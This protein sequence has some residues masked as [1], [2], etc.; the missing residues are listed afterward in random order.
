M[1][2]LGVDF[3]S[4]SHKTAGI[5]LREENGKHIVYDELMISEELIADKVNHIKERQP[6]FNP[7]HWAYR[8]FGDSAA[9]Q[10]RMEFGKLGLPLTSWKK[11]PVVAAIDCVRTLFLQDKLFIMDHCKHLINEIRAYQWHDKKP[12]E[13]KKRE[14]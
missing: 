5:G 1:Y 2:Y 3:G 9:N 12:D 7:K 13:P 6:T 8:S 4:I 14:R 11:E 10:E